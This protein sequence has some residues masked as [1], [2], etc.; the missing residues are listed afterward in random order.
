MRQVRSSP[1][2]YAQTTGKRRTI[3]NR[4]NGHDDT[5]R[6]FHNKMSPLF[7]H[8][9]LLL[10]PFNYLDFLFHFYLWQYL[11]CT[12]FRIL[13]PTQSSFGWAP[14][15]YD[16]YYKFSS[17][18]CLG[19]GWNRRLEARIKCAF[20]GN[21]LCKVVNSENNKRIDED[22]MR[23]GIWVWFFFLLLICFMALSKTHNG[24]AS[25]IHRRRW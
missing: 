12:F 11:V 14:C 20:R 7:T 22:T 3:G 8:Y 16:D 13:L 15:H 6:C 21:C 23:H 18:I 4:L 5:M 19:N 2:A 10:M 25:P 1:T 9:S 17:F 24:I